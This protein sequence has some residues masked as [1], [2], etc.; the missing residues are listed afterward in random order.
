MPSKPADPAA[1]SKSTRTA[2][3]PHPDAHPALLGVLTPVV[4]AAG[5][6]LE[7]LSV[8]VVGRRTVL[9]LIVDA[10]DQPDLDT[11]AAVSRL[12]SIALDE[13]EAAPVLKLLGEDY[14]LEVSSPGVDR[15][16]VERR[17]WTRAVGRLVTVSIDGEQVTGRVVSADDEGIELTVDGTAS[18]APA[19]T[20][21]TLTAKWPTIGPGKVR[22]EF[23][24][25]DA[26][27]SRRPSLSVIEG[28]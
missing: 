13:A 16:L 3:K 9:R 24:R 7:D 17:H 6:D 27:D 11:I 5:L 4:T 21:S 12:A 20:A 19:L 22:V 18:T 25:P 10:D 26:A 1:P 8:A 23:N 14:L 2:A 28:G 15:P